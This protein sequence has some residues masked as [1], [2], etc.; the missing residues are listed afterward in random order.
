MTVTLT[1]D[2]RRSRRVN[3]GDWIAK[4]LMASPCE[5][6]C[7]PIP[8][9]TQSGAVGDHDGIRHPAPQ[10]F[11]PQRVDEASDGRAR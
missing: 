11:A 2:F 6:I 9:N 7:I 3:C 10:C 8:A 1:A 4:T 5:H